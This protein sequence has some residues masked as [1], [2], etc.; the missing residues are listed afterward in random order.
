MGRDHLDV[1]FIEGD[2]LEFVRARTHPIA[3]LVDVYYPAK[4]VIACVPR[5][6]GAERNL[7]TLCSLSAAAMPCREQPHR[8]R[9]SASPGAGC[10][11]EGW[12]HA[13]SNAVDL[14]AA[15]PVSAGVL[16]CAPFRALRVPCRGGLGLRPFPS[17]IVITPELI[18]SR[19]QCRR[20]IVCFLAACA[21]MI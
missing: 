16:F 3:S 13:E 12:P 20:G 17:R 9:V 15:S 7:S 8:V 11:S 19:R 6:C 1:I 2:E 21:L 10:G 14:A 18:D 4:L 5:K